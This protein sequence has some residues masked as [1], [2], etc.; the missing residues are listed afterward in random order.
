MSSS[1]EFN[2]IVLV[3]IITASITIASCA[4]LL[5]VYLINALQIKCFICIKRSKKTFNNKKKIG[6]GS[7]YICLLI[8]SNFL[9]EIVEIIAINYDKIKD[10]DLK[11]NPKGSACQIFGLSH[12]LFDLSAICWTT[13][14][15]LLFYSS[16]QLGSEILFKNKKYF[17]L[18]FL[19]NFFSGF[20][21]CVI[22][23]FMNCYG[24][25]RTYCSFLDENDPKI[26]IWKYAFVLFALINSIY[27]IFCFYKT[28]KFYS[29][30][31]TL[32]K[33]RN[34]KEYSLVLIYVRVFQLFPVTLV[35]SRFVKGLYII[36]LQFYDEEKE[37]DEFDIFIK[38]L[39]YASNILYHLEGTFNSIASIFFF[40]GVFWCCTTSKDDIFKDSNQYLI[41]DNVSSNNSRSLDSDDSNHRL[42]NE[43][44]KL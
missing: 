2:A 30:K 37:F 16:T 5:I 15:T 24:F 36:I 22:P 35:V 13:M 27:N 20:I 32:L 34:Y 44:E 33:T 1:P 25:G 9:G 14:L 41:D 7:N 23:Y 40:R 17:L 28:T 12:K 3:K 38:I 8:L 39:I 18:G 10:G 4:L 31:L 42:F 29:R 19:Y 11:K 21:F 6:L 26:L 43:L